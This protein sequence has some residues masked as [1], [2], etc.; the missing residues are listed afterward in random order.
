M[1]I[2]EEGKDTSCPNE[3]TAKNEDADEQTGLSSFFIPVCLKCL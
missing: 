3:S 1:F 2:K